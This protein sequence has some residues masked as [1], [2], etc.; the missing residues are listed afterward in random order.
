MWGTRDRAVSFRS[1]E[2]L[3][4]KFQNCRLVSFPGVGHLPYE[5]A[6]EEFNQALIEFLAA[7][8]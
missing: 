7:G 8:T 5:E 2:K 4:Q 6:P 3:R 1:A